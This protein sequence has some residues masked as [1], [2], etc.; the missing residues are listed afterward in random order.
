MLQVCVCVRVCA[1]V[2]RCQTFKLAVLPPRSLR[3][4]P[5]HRSTRKHVR[6]F[7]K[8]EKSIPSSRELSPKLMNICVVL[9]S[10]PLVAK[11][12]VPRL[13]DSMTGSSTMVF[14]FHLPEKDATIQVH[15][16][17]IEPKPEPTHDK[18]VNRSYRDVG[19]VGA[20]ACACLR[21]NLLESQK[22][23]GESNDKA[24][25]QGKRTL[26]LGQGRGGSQTGP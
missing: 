19:W 10:L 7:A 4:L 22:R 8:G 21:A 23:S 1:C 9:E 3:T 2:A 12:T 18:H 17:I 16:G 26:L 6:T 15:F 14:V 11:E 5:F 25:K 24:N 20:C 13:F